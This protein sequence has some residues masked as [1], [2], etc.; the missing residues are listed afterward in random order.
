MP[1]DELDLFM[2]LKDIKV[3]FD[4]GA[5]TDMDYVRLRPDIE[6]HYFEPNPIFYKE[7]KGDHVNHF[8]LSDEDNLLMYYT[9]TQSFVTEMWKGVRL[10]VRTLDNYAKDIP[11]ID[12]LKIDTE[13]MDFKVLRGGQETLKK[14]RYIQFEFSSPIEQYLGLLKGFDLFLINDSRLYNDVIKPRVTDK[15][16]EKKLVPLT[17]DVIDLLNNEVIPLGAGGNIFA[18]K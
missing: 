6:I 5:R 12:F 15:K 1:K 17:Q 2:S 4:V 8:G 13:G 11:R 3:V 18:T 16:W 10:P 9:H 14:T 7:L